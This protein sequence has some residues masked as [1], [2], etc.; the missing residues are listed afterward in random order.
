[1]KQHDAVKRKVLVA[2]E[3]GD[4]EHMT[5]SQ[6]KHFLLP[7]VPQP[8]DR[9]KA[10]VPAAAQPRAAPAALRKHAVPAQAEVAAAASEP[11]LPAPAP[12]IAPTDAEEAAAT[13]TSWAPPG[14]SIAVAGA[15]GSAEPHPPSL[16]SDAGVSPEQPAPSA[17]QTAKS[18]VEAPTVQQRPTDEVPQQRQR[19]AAQPVPVLQLPPAGSSPA[20]IGLSQGVHEPPR[21]VTAATEGTA[22]GPAGTDGSQR[23]PGAT[24]A[25]G[26]S[27]LSGRTDRM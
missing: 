2:Y 15:V 5:V 6:L 26:M 20:G 17:A 14:D 13:I 9:R 10:P 8:S 25:H 1:M 7:D 24:V 27:I 16:S 23:D 21:E 4:E 3:D 22:G 11:P 19:S 12:D 18:A